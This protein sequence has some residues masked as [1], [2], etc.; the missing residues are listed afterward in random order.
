L[1][2]KPRKVKEEK[3]LQEESLKRSCSM[4]DGMDASEMNEMQI[5]S[6]CKP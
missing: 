6:N 1:Q 4:L 5:N 3:I 2:F